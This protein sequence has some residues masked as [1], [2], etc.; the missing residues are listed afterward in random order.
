M[1]A[2]RPRLPDGIGND[3]PG[4]GHAVGRHASVVSLAVLGAVIAIGL[5]GYAGGRS[6]HHTRHDETLSLSLSTPA[7]VRTGNVMETRLQVIAQRRI[8]RLIVGVEPG[9]W[10][11][12]TTNATLPTASSE[13]YVDGLFRFDFGPIEA[14][15]AFEFQISQQ[16]NPSLLG[17]NRG[18][19]V[20]LDGQRPLAQIPLRLTVLP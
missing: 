1:A 14:G 18:R 3:A 5:S 15:K 11:E 16:V 8:G 20:I 2:H 13:A 10:R 6:V 4:S 7:I 19:F 9:L 12:L 17:A